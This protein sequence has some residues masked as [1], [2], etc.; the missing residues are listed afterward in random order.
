MALDDCYIPAGWV[1]S[2]VTSIGQ[3]FGLSEERKKVWGLF[4]LGTQV[5]TLVGK[6]QIFIGNQSS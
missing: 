6:G 4:L 3:E 1:V 2:Q 5:C